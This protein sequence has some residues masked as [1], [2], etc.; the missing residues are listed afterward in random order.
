MAGYSPDPDSVLCILTREDAMLAL[1]D[2]AR[3]HADA[4]DESHDALLPDAYAAEGEIPDDAY[5]SMRATV[6][7][8]LSEDMPNDIGPYGMWVANGNDWRVEF[9]LIPG[10]GCDHVGCEHDDDT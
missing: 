10:V 4:D 9:W 5:G 2:M 7:S 3:D 1:M 8:I 6:D